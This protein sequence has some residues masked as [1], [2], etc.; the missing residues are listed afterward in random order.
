MIEETDI[1]LHQKNN[2]FLCEK[3]VVFRLDTNLLLFD[4][5]CLLL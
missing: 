2:I 4:V 3:D 5:K 1:L